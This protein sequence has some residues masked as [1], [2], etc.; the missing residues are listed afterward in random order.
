[1]YPGIRLWTSWECISTQRTSRLLLQLSCGFIL[2]CHGLGDIRDHLLL[3]PSAS[4]PPLRDHSLLLPSEHSPLLTTRSSYPQSTALT[5]PLAPLTLRASPSRDHLLLLPSEHR[6]H[7]TTCS[8]Y[9]QSITLTW[10]LALLTLRAPPSRDHVLLLPSEHHPH[11]TTPSSYP[12][13]TTLTWRLPPLTL[14]APPWHDDS[15]LLPSE[16][17]PDMTIPSSYP[18]SFGDRMYGPVSF[19][20]PVFV[21]F[22]TFG[23]VNG[24][25]FTS[26]RYTEVYCILSYTVHWLTLYVYCMLY[27]VVYSMLYT[28]IYSIL[29]A[30]V[31]VYSADTILLAVQRVNILT[32]LFLMSLPCK[33]L[34]TQYISKHIEANSSLW[35]F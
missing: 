35:F 18:Q 4:A 5:W 1:M 30:V 2:D 32:V 16:H 24:I 13:S 11:V 20:I 17:H 29:Y 3:L 33:L 21:A 28:V 12:Q 14:R 22:S 19:L 7:L 23:S 31:H 6:P 10:P 8:S 27:T 15:L 26:A 25:L 9:P 34:L